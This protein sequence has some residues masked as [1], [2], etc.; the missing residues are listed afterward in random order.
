MK[1]TILVILKL[2]LFMVIPTCEQKNII[3]STLFKPPLYLPKIINLKDKFNSLDIPFY[4]SCISQNH[5][6]Q[7]C[8]VKM[9]QTVHCQLPEAA[10]VKKHQELIFGLQV[11]DNI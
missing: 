8:P 5:D 3:L 7:Q 9:D 6:F 11:T 10:P 1:V 2:L 4:D